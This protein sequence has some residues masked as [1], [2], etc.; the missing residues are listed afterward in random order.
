MNKQ[1]APLIDP[2]E[3]PWDIHKLAEH[4]GIHEESVRRKIRR[5]QIPYSF[6]VGRSFRFKPSLIKNWEA[7]TR[8]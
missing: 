1:K 7:S 3:K 8:Q 2:K 6:R 4:L 5:K